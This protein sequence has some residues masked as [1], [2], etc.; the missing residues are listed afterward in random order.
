MNLANR[1]TM[2]RIFLVPIFLLF[3]A[4]KGIPYGSVLA[5]I[6]FIIASLTDKLDGY[7]ARSRNQI[8]NFGKFMDPLADKLLVTSA[9]VSLVELH[10]V[11]GWVAMIII[12]REFA[13]TGLRTIAAADGK[14]IAASKWGKLKTVIQIVAII[15]ALIN[16]A[17]GNRTINMV[18]NVKETLNMLTNVFMGAAVIITII[19]GVDYFVKNKG[20]IRVDK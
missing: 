8:T 18:V 7:I 2:I 11:Y 9:L 3:I 6:V 1:L 12:A 15:T 19:S 14:V 16:L 10:I 13:V 5:T 20:T 4:A 17:Y